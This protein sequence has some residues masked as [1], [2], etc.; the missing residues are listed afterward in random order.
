MHTFA[1]FSAIRSYWRV[2]FA[3][4]L[5]VEMAVATFSASRCSFPSVH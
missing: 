4:R 1:T 5:R 2:P 3:L